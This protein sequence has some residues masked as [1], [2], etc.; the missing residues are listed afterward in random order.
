[1]KKCWRMFGLG[2]SY[3][4]PEIHMRIEKWRDGSG[5]NKVPVYPRYD[6]QKATSPWL[7]DNW[8]KMPDYVRKVLQGEVAH[9]ER[10]EPQHVATQDPRAVLD[11]L[12]ALNGLVPPEMASK[13]VAFLQGNAIM[14]RFQQ[15]AYNDQ[16]AKVARVLDLIVSKYMMN[17]AAD[18]RL[19]FWKF[20]LTE[21]DDIET[22]KQLRAAVQKW[23]SSTGNQ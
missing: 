1:M 6:A 14:A 16:L 13:V 20:A 21:G 18:A 2:N 4:L 19:A 12:V 3:E 17:D 11:D 23:R 15:G 7:G 5:G 10:E 9:T 22:P 8:K